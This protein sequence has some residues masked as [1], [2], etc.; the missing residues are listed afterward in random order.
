L[1]RVS[2]V[3]AIRAR[4]LKLLKK[5]MKK[6]ARLPDDSTVRQVADSE[7][8][9]RIERDLIIRNER[10]LVQGHCDP[11]AFF[12]THRSLS[13]IR[14]LDRDIS[15]VERHTEQNRRADVSS[16]LKVSKDDLDADRKWLAGLFEIFVKATVLRRFGPDRVVMDSYVDGSDKRVDA[17]ISLGDRSICVEAT[18]LTG[19]DKDRVQFQRIVRATAEGSDELMYEQVDFGQFRHR[20]F[21]KVYEKIARG[22]DPSRSQISDTKPNLLLVGILDPTTP[23]SADS[24]WLASTLDDLFAAGPSE[25]LHKFVRRLARSDSTYWRLIEL[26]KKLSGICVFSR[27]GL[28]ASRINCNAHE[29]N[30]LSHREMA[31]FD[32]VFKKL[33]PYLDA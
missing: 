1:K 27:G 18:V 32:R 29:P 30:R 3:E 14:R 20:F 4:K 17:E 22:R 10:D 16:W 12:L 28:A 13:V 23:L 33:A 25:S 6:V 31:L 15:L 24:I 11:L 26:P 19:S 7:F 9:S 8:F 2:A 21:R 5:A